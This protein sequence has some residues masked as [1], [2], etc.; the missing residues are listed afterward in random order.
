MNLK[1]IINY[2]LNS[3]AWLH[4]ILYIKGT[5]IVNLCNER[6]NVLNRLDFCE[7]TILK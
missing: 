1:F 7:R 2:E 5:Q 6:A 4:I 3:H